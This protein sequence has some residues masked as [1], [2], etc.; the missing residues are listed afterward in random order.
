M[1][2]KENANK[3]GLG[4]RAI[5]GDSIQREEAEDIIRKYAAS[6][7]ME[8][9]AFSSDLGFE[10]RKEIAIVAKKFGLTTRKV[11]ENHNGWKRTF[12]VINKRVGPEFIIEQLER[13]GSWG[14]YELVRPTGAAPGDTSR[15]LQFQHLRK[16]QGFPEELQQLGNIVGEQAFIKGKVSEIVGNRSEDFRNRPGPS[17]EY[18]LPKKSSSGP[19][20]LMAMDLDRPM[21]M[22]ETSSRTVWSHRFSRPKEETRPNMNNTGSF[23]QDSTWDEG[24]SNFKRRLY[25]KMGVDLSDVHCSV[26]QEE[27]QYRY[28]AGIGRTGGRDLPDHRPMAGGFTGSGFGRGGMNQRSSAG[29]GNYMGM[30][31]N[32]VDRGQGE[33]Y[34][35]HN[36]G[37]RGQD[38][39]EGEA[40]GNY[41]QNPGGQFWNKMRGNSYTAGRRR[42]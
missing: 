41:S 29:F 25:Q 14:K 4:S 27:E 11:V 9:L 21:G 35:E 13:E 40:S 8:D 2:L 36:D 23:N 7:D 12:L 20:N 6:D 19:P 42:F 3:E 28:R 5:N 24:G 10:E 38:G 32:Y 37:Y 16:T 31:Q 30:A 34:D 18:N 17:S 33:Y 39:Y 1:Q 15:Y 22:V 26:E